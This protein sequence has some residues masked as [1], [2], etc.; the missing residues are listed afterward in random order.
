V[1]IERE[2]GE[3]ARELRRVV[4]PLHGGW[5][6][7][8]PLLD[9][10]GDAR[11]VLIGE[12]SHGTHDFYRVR[13]ELTKRLVLERGFQAVAV[14]GDWPD[15]YRVNRWVRGHSS[16]LDAIDA[17]ADFRRFPAWM[18]RNA[19]VLDFI[20]WLREH[21]EGIAQLHERV[22]F[23]GLDL[24]S[25]YGSMQEVLRYLDQNDP[26]SA[27]RARERYGCF[28]QFGADPQAYGMIAGLGMSHTCETEV[29]S[30]LLDLQRQR[31]AYLERDGFLANDEYFFAEQ[32][33]RVVHRAEQY[34]RA[35]FRGRV[36]SWNLRDLHMA[37]TLEALAS[38]LESS[39]PQGAKIV[40]WAHNSHVGDAR[41]TEMGEA[42][43]LNIGQLA[44]ERHPGETMLIGFSTFEGSVTAASNWGDPAE[45]KRVRPG[46]P[47]SYE[48][49][50]HDVAVPRFSLLTHELGPLRTRLR[51]PR[52]QRAIG[53]IYRPDTERQSHYFH[54]RLADQFDAIMHLDVT[55]AVEPLERSAAWG[56]EDLPE[57]YPTGV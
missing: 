53:V 28:D 14:E 4:H 2:S 1:A 17:L 30:Q 50:F 8:D 25:L 42:G 13:A 54:C 56:A 44:R 34:Y 29:V 52:L 22:G 45:R 40:V 15:A 27:M 35:M 48:R 11:F 6:D 7:F 57:T 51:E 46:L 9:R 3:L 10:I 32:N 55:R 49:L 18:W 36:S 37:D 33:A 31:A 26:Q 43:E 19:D 16:E 5:D 20:G 21:N 38:H 24:Y 47:G 41:A 23:Y 12:S 39:T